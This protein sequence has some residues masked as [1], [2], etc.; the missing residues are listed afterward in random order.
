MTPVHKANLM[1]LRRGLIS[2]L[3]QVED[4]LKLSPEKRSLKTRVDRRKA[5]KLKYK[6]VK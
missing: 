1:Q 6:S 2:T 3:K 4:E 5:N